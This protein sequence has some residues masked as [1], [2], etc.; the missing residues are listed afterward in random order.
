VTRWLVL[1]IAMP[2]LLRPAPLIIR[3]FD[4]ENLQTMAAVAG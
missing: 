2:I 1:D 3:S 4:E